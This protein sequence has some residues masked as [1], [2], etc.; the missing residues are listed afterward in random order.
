VN[1][2]S[3]YIF[4]CFC[5]TSHSNPL[6]SQ[7]SGRYGGVETSVFES[8]RREEVE[9]IA[10]FCFIFSA[11]FIPFL[12]RRRVFVREKVNAW[13]RISGSSEFKE[14]V[15]ELLVVSDEASRFC[16][17]GSKRDSATIHR[18]ALSP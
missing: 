1:K 3:A 11:L 18:Q 12:L 14:I 15:Q 16:E 17:L 5:S 6:P 7:P 8:E 9:L 2:S 10:T 4:T 13:I